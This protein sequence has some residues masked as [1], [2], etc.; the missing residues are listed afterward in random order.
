MTTKITS[1]TDRHLLHAP[2]TPETLRYLADLAGD[3]RCAVVMFPMTQAEWNAMPG[4]GDIFV[5]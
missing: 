5:N 3:E 1:P 4:A 2:A